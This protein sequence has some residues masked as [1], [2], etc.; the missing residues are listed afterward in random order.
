MA[1]PTEEQ[2][3]AIWKRHLRV[4]PA[5]EE[6]GWNWAKLA[7][8]LDTRGIE[9]DKSPVKERDLHRGKDW[10]QA[11]STGDALADKLVTF[12]QSLR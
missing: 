5:A 10:K 3:L 12:L 1:K 11:E 6:L 7:R 4:K 8:W 9:R 2:I